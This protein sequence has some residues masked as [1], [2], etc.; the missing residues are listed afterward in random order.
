MLAH[1]RYLNPDLSDLTTVDL[2]VLAAVR[3]PQSSDGLFRVFGLRE[4]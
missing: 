2:P 3:V 1:F 4:A